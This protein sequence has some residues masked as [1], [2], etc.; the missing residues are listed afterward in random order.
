MYGFEMNLEQVEEIFAFLD[1]VMKIQH[2]DGHSNAILCQFCES[3]TAFGR[4]H[5]PSA[6]EGQ[7]LWL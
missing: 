5:Y 1:H 3:F 6:F 2:L 4:V 7:V